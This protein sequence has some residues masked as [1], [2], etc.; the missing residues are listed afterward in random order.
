LIASL[1]FDNCGIDVTG[2][3]LVRAVQPRRGY[4]PRIREYVIE[5]ELLIEI[6]GVFSIGLLSDI[7]HEMLGRAEFGEQ[8]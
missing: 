8:I 1:A 3:K 5:F 6:D 7:K 2:K 4:T